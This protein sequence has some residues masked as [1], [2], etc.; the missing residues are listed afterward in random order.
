MTIGKINVTV[1][2]RFVLIFDNF[3][4]RLIW[5]SNGEYVTIDNRRNS[6]RTVALRKNFYWQTGELQCHSYLFCRKS[7]AR[8]SLYFSIFSLCQVKK[9]YKFIY[10]FLVLIFFFNMISL[11]F[12]LF[13][14]NTIL[15]QAVIKTEIKKLEIES[16]K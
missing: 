3:Y 16:A 8:F 15:D 2:Q 1:N 5:K 14:K 4:P 7:C 9:I 13:C 10:F 12:S 6:C 11:E